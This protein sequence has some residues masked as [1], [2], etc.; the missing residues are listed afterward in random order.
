[1]YCS[2]GYKCIC[3]L[4][5]ISYISSSSLLDILFSASLEYFVGQKKLPLLLGCVVWHV[6]GVRGILVWVNPI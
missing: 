2:Y 4:E 5:A 6:S 1:M 3:P